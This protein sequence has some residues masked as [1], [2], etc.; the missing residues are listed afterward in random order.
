MMM[1]MA[2]STFGEYAEQLV[3]FDTLTA[4]LPAGFA[5]TTT[6]AAAFV[7]GVSTSGA[8]LPVAPRLSRAAL[9]DALGL[10]GLL[11]RAPGRFSGVPTPEDHTGAARAEASASANSEK[12]GNPEESHVLLCLQ[13]SKK[14]HPAM[15]APLLDILRAD[16]KAII[17]FL[18]GER[19][20]CGS[21]RR[22]P[23]TFKHNWKLMENSLRVS[24]GGV[25]ACACVASRAAGGGGR[26]ARPPSPLAR[27]RRCARGPKQRGHRRQRRPV[28][29]AAV[30]P[31]RS[32]RLAP[33]TAPRRGR[34]PGPLPV[35]RGGDERR[36]PRGLPARRHPSARPYR[37]P[38]RPR[39]V[40]PV[41]VGA[42]G[43][44]LFGR[45]V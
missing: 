20:R 8:P 27:S 3:L 17:V 39:P 11:G 26:R 10:Q 38:A 16:P 12:D 42:G 24:L 34:L 4:A 7:P 5:G 18:E 35:G 37:A 19:R 44:G 29:A 1:S 31:P 32:P 21:F 13:H 30:L 41:A 28:G 43:W 6:S 45:I 9:L 22:L 36:E 25:A 23:S 40:S 2:E 14:I 33:R 15:D